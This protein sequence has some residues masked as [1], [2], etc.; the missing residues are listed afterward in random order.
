MSVDR[1]GRPTPSHRWWGRLRPPG[2]PR[3]EAA[4]AGEPCFDEPPR[5][6]PRWRRPRAVSNP[7]RKVRNRAC[8]EA[9]ARVHITSE[10]ALKGR[11]AREIDPHRPD[12]PCV[13]GNRYPRHPSGLRKDDAR[14]TA[15]D[16]RPRSDRPPPRKRVGGRERAGTCHPRIS[17]RA[18]EPRSL[19]ET[20]VTEGGTAGGERRGSD[21]RRLP[22]E[23]S[24]FEGRT[25]GSF[26]TRSQVDGSRKTAEHQ[27]PTRNQPREPQI[28][29]RLQHA[30]GRERSKPPR[31]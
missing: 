12:D 2:P 4:G 31:S 25:R 9:G 22:N 28:W 14:F 24:T 16:G 26:R 5:R 13:P 29:C 23:E 21:A 15:C 17:V 27:R 3:G 19:R 18:G 10:V 7:D 1:G 6:N 8:A 20:G 11:P 30:G